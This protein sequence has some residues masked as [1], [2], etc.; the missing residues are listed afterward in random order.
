[1]LSFLQP[2]PNLAELFVVV[3]T[4]GTDHEPYVSRPEWRA[5]AVGTFA[6][7][8]DAAAPGVFG[9]DKA[10]K[11]RVM[12][13]AEWTRIRREGGPAADTE[14]AARNRRLADQF[15]AQYAAELTGAGA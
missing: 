14:W 7:V 3:Q 4:D 1:M 12:S 2:P 15:A 9:P 13:V 11:I 8:L 6:A 5:E 10:L